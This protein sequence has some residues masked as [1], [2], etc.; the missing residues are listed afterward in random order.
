VYNLFVVEGSHLGEALVA[1]TDCFT[2]KTIKKYNPTMRGVSPGALLPTST[3][4]TLLLFGGVFVAYAVYKIFRLLVPSS[5]TALGDVAASAEQIKGTLST[6]PSANKQD[7]LDI[8]SESSWSALARQLVELGA[9][10]GYSWIC[11]NAPPNSH[12]AKTHELDFFWFILVVMF[13]A[14]LFTLH[15]ERKDL[16]ILN[17]DQS[18][19]WR[20]MMQVVFLLYHVFKLEEVYSTVRVFISCYVF[21]TGFGNTSF[22]YI[23]RDFGSVRLVQMLWRL[24]FSA[25]LLMMTHNNPFILYYIV[26]LHTF[27]FLMC[28]VALRIAEHVNH[29]QYGLRSK[30][31][32]LSLVIYFVWE[33][34]A[35]YNIAFFFLSTAKHP[36]APVGA[37][38]VKVFLRGPSFC[39]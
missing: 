6:A 12:G 14:S 28:F 30:L 26:P 23:K 34:Q 36:G 32:I 9:I 25:V 5:R 11:E 10:L 13:V 2:T 39:F 16:G 37:Y 19:E 21:L 7:L 24:M 27:Y 35:V 29:S 20:G 18:E 1:T 22:F 33:F 8:N 15:S 17:R 4:A 31:V 3:L 38:G